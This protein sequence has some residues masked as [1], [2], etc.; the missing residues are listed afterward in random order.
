MLDLS[1]AFDTLDHS[2][3]FHRLEHRFGITGTVLNWFKSYL[4]NRTQC[5][6]IKSLP[7]S[8]PVNLDCGV[9]QGSVLGPILFTL[10]TTPLEDIFKSND[11]DSMFYADDTQL[12]VICNKPSD[13]VHIIENC[14]DE[15]RVWMKSNLLILNADKTEIIHFASR[16]KNN[17]EKLD[18]LRIGGSDIIPSH[19]IRNLGVY[20]ESTGSI[21]S[22]VNHISKSC[23]FSLHRLSKIRSCLN[24]S[25][26]E[27]LVHAFITSRLDYCNSI[28]YGCPEN[29]IKKLQ[30][31]QNSAA[32]L[33]K[34]KKKS[35]EITPIL[36]DL[37]WLPIKERIVF[38]LLMFVYKI[39]NYQAPMY[40]T[41]LI[42]LYVPG[43][44]GLR[45]ANPD[46]LLLQRKDT[47]VTN[48]T[49][50]WRAFNICAPFYGINY[51]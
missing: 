6:S 12:Y 1:A 11:I 29:E 45:S 2:V 16:F 9:P 20:Q 25:T 46:L 24:Q 51:L 7:N 40:L 4:S 48:K 41:L 33:I 50:G 14:L 47:N 32:R 5:V 19:C 30:A 31:I 21:S 44:T 38:K 27:K 15:I 49:Y 10:Y 26:T 28:L 18:S 34:I 22:H 8:K 42:D 13:N 35:D 43:R 39:L 17:I 37:H 36:Y 23:F 3:L